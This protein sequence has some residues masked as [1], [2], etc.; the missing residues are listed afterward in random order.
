MAAAGQR[1]YLCRRARRWNTHTRHGQC[2]DRARR[3]NTHKARE[4]HGQSVVLRVSAV[5]CAARRRPHLAA[6]SCGRGGRSAR[7]IE[8]PAP[9]FFFWPVDKGARATARGGATRQPSAFPA[10]KR[11][12][13]P[14]SLLRHGATAAAVVGDGY[15]IRAR[16]CA[17]HQSCRQLNSEVF[18]LPVLR[19]F[20]ANA[21]EGQG[22]AVPVRGMGSKKAVKGRG[23]AVEGSDRTR[24][25]S[26][27]VEGSGRR[28]TRQRSRQRQRNLPV[29]RLFSEISVR[30]TG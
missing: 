6:S 20:S 7:T 18:A 26:G 12:S 21:V 1:H 5:S 24:T 19:V 22:N 10:C 16:Q 15:A 30:W 9:H 14:P 28:R 13:L 2:L 8:G 4:R 25:G 17:A 23:K 11:F 3:W 29:L 27:K